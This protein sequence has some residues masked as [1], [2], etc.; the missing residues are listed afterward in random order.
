ME[1]MNAVRLSDLSKTARV[2]SGPEVRPTDSS[3][4]FFHCVTNDAIMVI[5]SRAY[6]VQ[7]L[8]PPGLPS[9]ALKSP[10][11]DDGMKAQRVT[12]PRT[13]LVGDIL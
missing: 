7:V 6:S 12:C 4:S 2:Q 11:Q 10:F 9:V 13:Q 5:K 3:P 1:V 8:M